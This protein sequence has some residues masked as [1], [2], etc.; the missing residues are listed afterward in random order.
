MQA[1]GPGSSREEIEAEA[2]RLLARLSN[3]PTAQD[4]ADLC[5]WIEADPQHAIAYARAEAAWEAAERLKSAA[6]GVSLPPMTKIFREEQQRLLSRNIIIAVGIAVILF[7]V[8]AI[9][10]V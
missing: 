1:S 3:S 10:T 6:A 2:A 5:A 7:V 4:E 8:A 9:I